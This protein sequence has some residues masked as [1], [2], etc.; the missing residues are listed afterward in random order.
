[1]TCVGF[2]LFTPPQDFAGSYLQ[3]EIFQLYLNGKQWWH[4]NSESSAEFADQLAKE[5]P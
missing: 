2:L 1:M 5:M 3:A 4:E